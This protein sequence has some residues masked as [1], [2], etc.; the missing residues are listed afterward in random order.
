MAVMEIRP[1]ERQFFRR[2][3]WEAHSQNCLSMELPSGVKYSCSFVT[4]R[5]NMVRLLVRQLFGY[6]MIYSWGNTGGIIID[7]G[8]GTNCWFNS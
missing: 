6:G 2:A 4:E 7:A 3:F 1:T 8:Q 5:K